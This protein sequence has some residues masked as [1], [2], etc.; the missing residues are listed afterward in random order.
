MSWQ[1]RRGF[2]AAMHYA[3]RPLSDGLVQRVTMVIYATEVYVLQANAQS[4]ATLLSWYSCTNEP[5][6]IDPKLLV[7]S[8][9]ARCSD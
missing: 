7:D 6:D 2:K 5:A 4:R 9:A 3:C 1:S 8:A